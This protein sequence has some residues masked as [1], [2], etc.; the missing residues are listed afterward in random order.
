M[1][2]LIIGCE[3]AGKQTLARHI[4]RWLIEKMGEKV[5]RW[6]DHFVVPKLDQHTIFRSE[7]DTSINNSG[8]EHWSVMG[9]NA[10]DQL[11]NEDEQQIL[12][13]RPTVLEQLQRHNI[14]RHLH[15]GLFQNEDLLFINH[16]YADAVYA[17]LYYGYGEDGSFADR[18]DRARAWDSELLTSGPSITLVLV[19]ADPQIVKDR[20]EAAP[21]A[22]GILKSADIDHVINRFDEEYHHSLLPRKFLLDTSEPIPQS[23]FEK[24]IDNIQPFLT[25]YDMKRLEDHSRVE[26]AQ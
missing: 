2:L 24:F 9:K 15:H 4:S 8:S 13:L 19:R 23:T 22:S 26:N 5:V 7:G 3:Y 6:H 20:L 12:T 10:H 21:R 17:P 14:W 16:Y 1:H 18:R 11:T 25:Q